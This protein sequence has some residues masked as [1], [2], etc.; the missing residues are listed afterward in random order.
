MLKELS[1]VFSI[2]PDCHTP[3]VH[4]AVHTCFE[5]GPTKP[6]CS[7][8]LQR[9]VVDD[10]PAD[11][12]LLITKS[13]NGNGRAYSYPETDQEDAPLCGRGSG[14]TSAEHFMELSR[15]EAKA[16]NRVP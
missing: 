5:K 16:R 12:P 8:R 9:V 13:K 6:R 14:L 2:C 1:V 11:D 4:L 3:V 15:A 7:E 10:R